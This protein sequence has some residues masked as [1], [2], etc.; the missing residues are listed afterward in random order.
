MIGLHEKDW[1]CGS[2]L[3]L[4]FVTIVIWAWDTARFMFLDSRPKQSYNI[5]HCF[6]MRLVNKSLH[7]QIPPCDC[8]VLM[9]KR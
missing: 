5:L 6:D 2:R 8:H 1:V 4:Y 7:L 9:V 3:T